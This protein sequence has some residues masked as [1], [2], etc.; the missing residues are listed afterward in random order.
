VSDTLPDAPAGPWAQSIRLAFTGLFGLVL[1]AALAWP[2]TN[3]RQ[4]QPDSR[5]VVLRLGRVVRVQGAG[6]L[7]AWPKPFERVVLLPAAERQIEYTFDPLRPPTDAGA[8][9]NDWTVRLD[10]RENAAFFMTGDGVV[11]MTAA[12]FYRI[13]DPAA[14]MQAASHVEPSL[15][16]LTLASLVDLVAARDTDTLVVTRS[17]N[18]LTAADR[19]RRERLRTDLVAAIGKRLA[20]LADQGAGIGVEVS[21]VDLATAL[22]TG[23]K[24]AFEGVL[25]A[26]QQSDYVVAQA[27]SEAAHAEQKAQSDATALL[28]D[29]HASAEERT[30]TA[31]TRTATIRT[32][33]HAAGGVSGEALLTTIYNDRMRGLLKQ[34]KSVDAFDPKSG[35]RLV[36]PGQAAP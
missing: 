9:A 12:V 33:A 14:Y 22:P 27:R 11:H 24:A 26:S 5:A 21:R 1:L 13:T 8:S 4:V 10:P 20:D 6:L 32:L 2:F 34:A 23:A 29:A 35:T 28:A 25:V 3:L 16:A 17:G 19:E 7:L 30:T 36:L 18:D 15:R 31:T